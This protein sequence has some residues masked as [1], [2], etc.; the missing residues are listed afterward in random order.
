MKF[1][2]VYQR[3]EEMHW[4]TGEMKESSETITKAKEKD[5]AL[6]IGTDGMM[7]SV[8]SDDAKAFL[9]LEGSNLQVEIIESGAYAALYFKDCTEVIDGTKY[10]MGRTMIMK[11]Q[12][13]KL[14][15]LSEEESYDAARKFVSRLVTLTKDG[16][17]YSAYE[18]S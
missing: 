10:L 11:Y 7:Y 16:Y 3:S 4:K 2:E 17:L 13:N 1:E 5:G 8:E 18:L 12:G 6:M 9:Y 15:P 14:M